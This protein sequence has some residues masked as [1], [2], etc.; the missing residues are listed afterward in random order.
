MKLLVLVIL[1]HQV[2]SDCCPAIR[3]GYSELKCGDGSTLNGSD[4]YCGHGTCNIL[5]CNCIG[6]CRD[7]NQLIFGSGD[8]IA[9]FIGRV[10][11]VYT[12][13]V[14]LAINDIEVIHVSVLDDTNIFNTTAIVKKDFFQTIT[15]TGRIAIHGKH[16]QIVT[17]SLKKHAKRASL[18]PFSL[19]KIIKRATDDIDLKINYNIF[20]TNCEHLVTYWMFGVGFNMQ[21]FDR[22][23][24]AI[25]NFFNG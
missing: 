7:S 24:I 23:S 14:M 4:Y 2:I 19:E 13:H 5:G 16:C 8:V 12:F 9:C 10:V 21:Q 18:I 6:G 20:K 15:S 11:D 3:F 1:I 22:L 17:D 25:N